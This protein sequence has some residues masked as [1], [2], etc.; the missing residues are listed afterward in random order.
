[1]KTWTEMKNGQKNKIWTKNENMDK[2][3]INGQK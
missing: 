3:Y 2:N 1:M